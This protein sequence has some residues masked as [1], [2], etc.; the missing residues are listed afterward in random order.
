MTIRDVLNILFKR[1]YVVLGFFL[2]ALVGGFAGLKLFPATYESTARLLVRIGQ[3]DIYVPTLSSTQFRAPMMSVVREEQLHSEAGILTSENLSEQVVDE[4]TPQK[5]FP[6]IDVEHPW[7]TPKGVV[8]G[9]TQMYS[10][11]EGYFFPQSA[12]RSLRS[13]AVSRMQSD[14]SAE[15]VKSSNIIEVSLRNKS[16]EAAALGVNTLVK[17]YLVER[18]RIYQ[19]E[20]TS[21]I[22]SQLDELESQ[23]K[24][25]ERGLGSL[26][27][28]RQVVDVDLQRNMQIDKL[29]DARK[30]ID[31]TQVMIDQTERQNEVLRQQL[32]NVP[33][34][35]ELTGAQSSNSF[36]LSE[37]SKQLTDLK[38]T[39][40]ETISRLS[41]NDPK[42]VPLRQE[43][44]VVEQQISSQKGQRY[45][46]SER[47]IN[48][49]NARL[50]DD[51]MRN[52]SALAGY[53]QALATLTQQE[54]LDIERLN[55]LNGIEAQFKEMEQ[56]LGVLRD[57]RKLYLERFE[58]TRFL[59]QQAEAQ[60]GNVSVVNWASVNN[61]PVSPKL[62]L[63]LVGVLLGGLL[64]GIGLAFVFEILDDSLKSE[65]DVQ[66][67]L[68]LTVIAKVPQL[69]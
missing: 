3:E 56:K 13:R 43:I 45:A 19:R 47:G 23:I 42:I 67:Y 10:A 14:L 26:R 18:V 25:T 8:Q 69:G 35:T 4:V 51:L 29:K 36:A 59:S 65:S 44:A 32:N 46:S 27:S 17:R 38:R 53:R 40:A 1:R 7:Y 34:T 60:I 21:F 5:L 39:E 20:K 62:W 37:L 33:R 30:N 31:T 57:S 24:T 64:G 9:L 63:V 48:P 52:E 55:E 11:I 2:A 49:L 61:R 15:P 54:K 41:A 12:D 58:E 66:R 68:G 50:R 6:G 22:S 16:A 28:E